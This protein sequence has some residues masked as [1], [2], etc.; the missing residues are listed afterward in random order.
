MWPKKN[1][2]LELE[3]EL[4]GFICGEVALRVKCMHMENAA[5]RLFVT[6]ISDFC[7]SRT[8]SPKSKVDSLLLDQSKVRSSKIDATEYRFLEP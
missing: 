3:N 4:F 7:N 1:S 8:R 6:R 2:E 5:K